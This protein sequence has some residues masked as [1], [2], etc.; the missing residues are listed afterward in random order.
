MNPFEVELGVVFSLGSLTYTAAACVSIHALVCGCMVMY[1]FMKNI[2]KHSSVKL[3]VLGT[4]PSVTF[5]F[6]H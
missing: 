6:D 2:M 1:V 4:K 3:T 5:L